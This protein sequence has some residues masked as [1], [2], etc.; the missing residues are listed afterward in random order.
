MSL[1]IFFQNVGGGISSVVMGCKLLESAK[2]ESAV[3][4]G[5]PWADGSSLMRER[6]LV[7]VKRQVQL[8]LHATL[9]ECPCWLGTCSKP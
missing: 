9:Q 1:T 5:E 8:G 4:V 2:W 3:V 6:A 7:L